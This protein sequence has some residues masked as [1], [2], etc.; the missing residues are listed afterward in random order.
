[1]STTMCC[2]EKSNFA[3]TPAEKPITPRCKVKPIKPFC[4]VEVSK[5]LKLIVRQP[6]TTLLFLLFREPELITY[7]KNISIL[8][9]YSCYAFEDE[10]LSF[11]I[12]IKSCKSFLS[13][14]VMLF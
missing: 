10:L 6:V 3:L 13:S 9:N 14:L 12:F 5:N 2:T 4:Y 8:H 1:M 7:K 11:A